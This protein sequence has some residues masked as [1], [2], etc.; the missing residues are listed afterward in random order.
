[1]ADISK[2]NLDVITDEIDEIRENLDAIRM[3]TT[4]KEIN[5][6]ADGSIERLERVQGFLLRKLKKV[7]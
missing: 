6:L 5:D 2:H 7:I 1:M 3:R 4:N